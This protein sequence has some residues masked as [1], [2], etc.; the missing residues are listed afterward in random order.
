[1]RVK[2]ILDLVANTKSGAKQAQRDLKGV[3]DAAKSLDGAKGGQRISRDF[4][5]LASSSKTATRN[6]KDTK[7]ATDALGRSAGAKKLGRELDDVARKAARAKAGMDRVA[8]SDGRLRDRRGRFAG[9]G[10]RGEAGSAKEGG[11]TLFAGT[12]GLLG[13]YLGIQGARMAARGTVGQSISF[14]KAM[15]EVR[16]KVDGMDNPAELQK[17][18]Q[19][20]SKWAIAYGRAR[21]EVASLVAEA[22]AG[23]VT[24][25]DMPEFVR[26]NLAAATAWDATADKTGNALAKIRAAT[27]W[28]NKELEEFGDKVNALS[29]A[30]AAKE[31]DVVDMF[32]RAGAAAKAAGVEFDT[33]LAFLT[34][35]NNVAIAPEVA[36]RGFAALSSTLRTG[37]GKKYAEGLAML[38]LT[39]GKVKAGMKKNATG[40]I[41]DFLER[42]EKSS[43][44]ADAAI[45]IVGKEWWD[46]VART[47]QALPEIRKNLEIVQDPKKWQGSMA[48]NLNIQLATTDNHL[49]RL[50]AQASEVGDRLGRWALPAI[51]EGIEKIIAGMDALDKRAADKKA[52][53]SLSEKVAA[54]LPLSAEERE[55][56]ANDGLLAARVKG[57]SNAISA[58]KDF[59]DTANRTSQ[60][61]PQ[62][63]LSERAQLLRRQLQ[64]QIETLEAELKLSPDGFGDRKKNKRL[65]NLRKQLTEI[66]TGSFDLHASRPDARRP[67]DQDERGRPDRSEVMALRERV[68]QLESRLTTLDELRRTSGNRDDRLGF[69]G[70]ALAYERRR[71]QADEQLRNRLAPNA[72]A[73]GRFGFGPGGAPVSAQAKGAG[74]GTASFRP[75]IQNWASSV[76]GAQDID[77]SGIGVTIAES[78][79]QGLRSGGSSAEAAAGGIRSGI[80]GAFSGADL[81]A[82]GAHMMAT[83]EQGLTAG[84]DRA[85]AAAQ[86]IGARLKGALAAGGRQSLSG[87]LHDG[88]E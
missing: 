17:M 53:A 64:R 70:D 59:E 50:S 60:S 36:S 55:R 62:T 43:E 73:A 33:S 15:A 37:S 8:A 18:E 77:L 63:V 58:R 75:S 29:D 10:G 45:K 20:V 2:M 84:G 80:T 22:G 49:K 57:Q 21:E 16:K 86:R 14:E 24:L 87:A 1:M 35:M 12:K 26:I 78:L 54:G 32:Q 71:N 72:T 76:L 23:G 40:T 34:A 3:K 79:A 61:D 81:S 27:Q 28:G 38:G 69:G 47:G 52:E 67:A 19:A 30:G 7:V 41:I 74:S 13:G 9:G 51:N 5:N 6:L 85:V 48:N 25:K 83:L 88:V 42:L 11:S 44:K 65:A 56:L 4:L 82:A 68:L 31:M 46:E 39:P 66:P